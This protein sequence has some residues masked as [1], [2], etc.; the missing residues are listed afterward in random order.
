MSVSNTSAPSSFYNQ[1]PGADETF[2]TVSSQQ[3]T[4][5]NTTD[6]TASPVSFYTEGPAATS[7]LI[8]EVGP[9]TVAQ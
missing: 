2:T 4:P 1:G 3:T 7:D 5:T 6:N 9:Q 8:V